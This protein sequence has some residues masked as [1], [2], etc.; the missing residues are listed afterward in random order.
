MKKIILR[1]LWVMMLCSLLGYAIAWIVTGYNYLE[2]L[3][4][5]DRQ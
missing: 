2:M 4:W 1:L 5:I 3:D